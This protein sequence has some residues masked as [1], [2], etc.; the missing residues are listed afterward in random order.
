VRVG[1]D[2]ALSKYCCRPPCLGVQ[3][4]CSDGD[5]GAGLV[6]HLPN[7]VAV[8]QV[9]ACSGW[10]TAL[11]VSTQ[12][13][14]CIGAPEA[15]ESA[16]VQAP[17]PS[18]PPPTSSR[19]DAARWGL[20]DEG[21]ESGA[22]GVVWH[23]GQHLWMHR[24]TG[25]WASRLRFSCAVSRVGSQALRLGVVAAAAAGSRALTALHLNCAGATPVQPSSRA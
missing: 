1:K 15:A 2:A 8:W 24:G 18:Q 5:V 25:A 4:G 3:A 13:H 22:G 16:A 10:Q 19:G 21:V 14:W 11:L 20:E 17:C 7:A 9:A 23:R 12:Q 6:N